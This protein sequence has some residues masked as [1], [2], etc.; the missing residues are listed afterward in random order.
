MRKF[1][2]VHYKDGE[3]TQSVV[4]AYDVVHASRIV[5]REQKVGAV[6]IFSVTLLKGRLGV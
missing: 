4:E 1:V 3:L 2:V 6:A 5:Q